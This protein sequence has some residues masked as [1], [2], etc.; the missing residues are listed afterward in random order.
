MTLSEMLQALG[1]G[2]VIGDAD[3]MYRV[4]DDVYGVPTL[5][6]R[7]SFDFSW[8]TTNSLTL[9]QSLRKCIAPSYRTHMTLP[10]GCPIEEVLDDK[11]VRSEEYRDSTC[12][13]YSIEKLAIWEDSDDVT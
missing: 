9:R 8:A 5:Q 6:W 3:G 2:S 13:T 4:I 12:V 7:R 10:L 1:D 11:I